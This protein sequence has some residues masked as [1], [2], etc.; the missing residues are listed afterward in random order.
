MLTDPEKARETVDADEIFRCVKENEK[1]LIL[2]EQAVFNSFNEG[3]ARYGGAARC[4]SSRRRDAG[5]KSLK[6]GFPF[7]PFQR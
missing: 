3:P 5:G 6:C 1:D 2:P 4:G 7:T